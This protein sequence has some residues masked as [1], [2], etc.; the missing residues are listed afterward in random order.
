MQVARRWNA[1]MS[2]FGALLALAVFAVLVAGGMEW[3]E[4]RAEERLQRLAG[5]QA[6]ALS[7]AVAV[8]VESDFEARLASAPRDVTLATLRTAGVL[9]PGFAA[10]GRDALG[11]PYRVLMRRVPG[12]ALDV[13]VTQ[14][15]P[16]GDD[17]LPVNAAFGAGGQV[18]IGVVD[19]D[20]RPVVLRGPA[21][22]A[23]MSGFRG[24]FPGAPELRAI[25]VLQRFD[26][27]SVFGDFLYRRNI[28]GL[29]GANAMETDLHMGGNDVTGARNVE[30]D[31]LVLERDLQVGGSLRVTAG[32]LVGGTAQVNGIATVSG[33]L[34]ADSASVVGALS[35]DSGTIANEMRSNRVVATGEVRAGSIGTGGAL[36]AGSGRIAGPVVAALVAAG[37]ANVRNDVVA[38]SARVGSLTAASATVTG[39][40]NVTGSVTAGSVNARSSVTANSAGF[41]SLVVGNCIGC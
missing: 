4:E 6:A 37:R 32:L 24:D 38:A 8:W 22:R 25:G 35:A 27:Q 26:R 28:A 39:T 3:L 34:R 9:A 31:E 1:G 30:A 2:L 41:S 11:R 10:N 12:D 16:A 17:L 5:A 29:P 18:R 13:L 20:A 19:P 23:D 40:A 7:E 33:E 21:I 14:R 36:S 15:V